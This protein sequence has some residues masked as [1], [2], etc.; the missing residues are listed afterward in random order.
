MADRAQLS[1][2]IDQAIRALEELKRVWEAQEESAP[3]AAPSR[4][5]AAP[6]TARTWQAAPPAA[7]AAA[8]APQQAA[9]Q[10]AVPAFH[11]SGKVCPVC[12]AQVGAQ[13]KFC[14]ECGATLA[15][16]AAPSAAPAAP[17]GPAPKAFC[18]KCGSPL[19]P[20]DRFCMKCGT[21][22]G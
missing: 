8:P 6:A 14:K 18:M 21:P 22:A 9:A 2:A 19:K 15:A 1:E 3:A 20:G 17:S 12:G 11:A 5:A 10:K 7:P 16:A 13:S 4:Q